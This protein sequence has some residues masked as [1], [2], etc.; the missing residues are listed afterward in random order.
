MNSS[1]A[2]GAIAHRRQLS[3]RALVIDLAA[4]LVFVA[5]STVWAGGSAYRQDLLILITTYGLVA[6]ALYLHFVMGG[7]LS[8]A[9]NAYLGIGAYSV[10]WVATRTGLPVI[11]GVLAGMVLSAVIA[12]I[13]GIVTGRL[14]GFYLAAVTLLFGK[15]F[16]SWL[17]DAESV[18]GGASGIQAIP[19]MALGSHTIT[20]R[21]IAITAVCILSLVTV[22]LSAMRRSPFGMAI[23]ASRE[24]PHGLAACAVSPV[25]L[26]WIGLSIGAALGSLGGS[27]FVAASRSILPESLTLAVVLLA[28]FMPVLGGVRSP[29]GAVIGAVLVVQFTFNLDLLAGSGSLLF[30]LAV[31]GVIVLAPKGLLGLWRRPTRRRALQVDGST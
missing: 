12:F 17:I 25:R 14:S 23:R 22:V 9:Y 19:A 20:R 8:I 3:R 27:I 16:Q 5:I 2:L 11:V 4:T 28:V 31:L 29:W 7:R 10:G 1:D 30:A 15:A 24:S 6:L 13:L 21:E 26:G 18:T